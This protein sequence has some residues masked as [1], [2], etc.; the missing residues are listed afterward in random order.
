ME[1]PGPSPEWRAARHR[2]RNDLQML[3]SLLRLGRRRAA[4]EELLAAFPEWLHAMAAVYDLLP[5]PEDASFSLHALI[6][7]LNASGRATVTGDARLPG[8]AAAA[9]ALAADGLLAFGRNV[10]GPESDIIMEVAE[11][12]A[13]AMRVTIRPPREDPAAGPPLGLELAADALGGRITVEREPGRI[14]VSLIVP[15]P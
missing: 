2:M 3:A 10:A 6:S 1:T 14:T 15:C 7:A 11:G 13:I 9:A 5:G 8:E 12:R 4:P